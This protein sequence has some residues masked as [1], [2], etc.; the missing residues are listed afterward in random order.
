MSAQALLIGPRGHGGEGVYV[1]SLEEHPPSG[2][3]YE[4]CGDFHH[5]APG[6]PCTV[7]REL[8]LNRIVRRATIPDMGFR[9]VRLRRR[10]DLV[11]VHAHPVLLRGLGRTPL[12]MSEGSSS[13][14][15]LGDY[16]G[17]N[18]EQLSRGYRRSRRVYR[19][20]GIHD[21]LLSL[22]RVTRAY[23]FSEWARQINLRW[24]ADPDKLEVLYPGFPTPAPVDRTGR[25]RFTFLFVGGDFERKGGFE[26]IDAFVQIADACPHAHL[27]IA[28]SDPARSNPDR[29]IHSWVSPARQEESRRSLARL[30]RTDRATQIPWV[31]HARVLDELFP[32]ADAFVMPTYA[33]GFGFTNVEAMS[34]GLPVITSNVGPAAEI[35]TPGETGHLVTPGAVDALAETMLS[36]ATDPDGA[37]KMGE[38][39]RRAFSAKFTRARFQA[40]LG[41]FYASA[42][43]G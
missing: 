27:V 31:E 1:D 7:L 42:I 2:F 33:E 26:V 10:F 4:R 38:A 35:V 13:A 21:R 20:L 9:A 30:Q 11:H 28:G 36:V 40:A 15:Y 8:T 24:G 19:T 41:D 16:L 23:V 12:V 14:V 29:A 6:A 18:E 5:G 22:E 34:F 32:S 43:E 37:A 39:G 3:H 25:E 17:W